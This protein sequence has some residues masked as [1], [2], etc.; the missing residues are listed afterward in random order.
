MANYKANHYP[1]ITVAM[2]GT[3]LGYDAMAKAHPLSKPGMASDISVGPDGTLWMVSTETDPDAGG[4]KIYWSNADGKWTEIDGKAPGGFRVSGCENASCVYITNNYEL[5]GYNQEKSSFKLSEHVYDIDYSHGYYWGLVPEKPGGIP[6]L[7]FASSNNA[8]L[9]W[10]VF[11]G[12][13]EVTSISAT[14]Q[15]CVALVDQIPTL[16]KLK[17]QVQSPMF[18]GITQRAM[19]ISSKTTTNAIVSFEASEQGN[20]VL[21]LSSSPSEQEAYRPIGDIQAV[22]MTTSYFIPV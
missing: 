15:A 8:P 4:K 1:I 20:Q 10:T 3:V 14:D 2:D 21:V 19:Q 6:V 11:K 18:P 5:Y 12:N 7:Q 16:F 9:Q 13:V 22:K 17:G